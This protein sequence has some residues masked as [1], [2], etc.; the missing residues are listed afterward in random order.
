MSAAFSTSQCGRFC[1]KTKAISSGHLTP[2]KIGQMS[3]AGCSTVDP[4]TGHLFVCDY[5]CGYVAVFDKTL[6]RIGEV[7]KRRSCCAKEAVD[8]FKEICLKPRNGEMSWPSGIAVQVIAPGCSRLLV[9]DCNLRC[10]Q[11]YD[12]KTGEF[13]KAIGDQP[14]WPSFTIAKKCQGMTVLASFWVRAV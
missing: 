6:T 12:T 10:I 14:D 8:H 4:V 2:G 9:S 3:F 7:G 11:V 13:V 5:N 1:E